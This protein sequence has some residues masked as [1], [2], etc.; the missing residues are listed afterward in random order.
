MS[1]SRD[2]GNEQSAGFN[3]LAD[4]IVPG[5]AATKLALVEPHSDAVRP[6]RVTDP[7][8]RRGILRG[9]IQEDGFGIV[10]HVRTGIKKAPGTARLQN[11][12]LLPTFAALQSL[13]L[14]SGCTNRGVAGKSASLA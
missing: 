10:A 9:I 4:G 14:Q 6:Q 11:S 3:P 12:A 8:G 13:T 7:A 1:I 2:D 5:I